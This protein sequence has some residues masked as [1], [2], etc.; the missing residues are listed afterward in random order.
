M[1]LWMWLKYNFKHPLPL[2]M[3]AGPAGN[4]NLGMFVRPSFVIPELFCFHCHPLGWCSKMDNYTFSAQ[5]FEALQH[6]A[7]RHGDNLHNTRQEIQELTRN[8][9]RL[10]SEIEHVKKQVWSVQERITIQSPWEIQVTLW[11][12]NSPLQ[13]ERISKRE[14]VQNLILRTWGAYF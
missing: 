2:T 10:R 11:V 3:L 12:L 7:G 13:R 6:T 1:A 9:Q 5:Q 4:C 8:I 14:L